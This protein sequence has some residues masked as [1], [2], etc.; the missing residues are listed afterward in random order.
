MLCAVCYACGMCVNK[1]SEL[2]SCVWVQQLAEVA[3]MLQEDK[4]LNGEAEY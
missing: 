3:T 4:C 2:Q 1:P